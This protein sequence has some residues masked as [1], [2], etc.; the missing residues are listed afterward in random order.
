MEKNPKQQ[1]HSLHR[2]PQN[3]EFNYHILPKSLAVLLPIH[4]RM[5]SHILYLCLLL[6]VLLIQEKVCR[7]RENKNS[8]T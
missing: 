3:Q 8:I 7:R 4:S 6:V 2:R 5:T 1:N